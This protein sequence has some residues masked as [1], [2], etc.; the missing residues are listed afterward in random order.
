MMVVVVGCNFL[1]STHDQN[2]YATQLYNIYLP[3]I[4]SGMDNFIHVLLAHYLYFEG[5][6]SKT[7]T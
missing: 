4:K 3:L 2:I 7:I 6:L 5:K 1:H